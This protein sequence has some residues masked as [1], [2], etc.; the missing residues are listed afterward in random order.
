M[1]DYTLL[2]GDDRAL[3]GQQN[4]RTFLASSAESVG[5]FRLRQPAKCVKQGDLDAFVRPEP[6]RSSV[7]QFCLAVE[8][9]DSGR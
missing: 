7:S 1:R 4:N 3:S 9:F 8:T 2:A 5:T 6:I